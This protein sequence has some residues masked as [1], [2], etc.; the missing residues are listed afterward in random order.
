ML[1]RLLSTLLKLRF[2]GSTSTK[3][4]LYLSIWTN[5]SY[6]P[7][8]SFKSEFPTQAWTLKK[9]GSFQIGTGN[10]FST[11]FVGTLFSCGLTSGHGVLDRCFHYLQLFKTCLTLV[12][13]PSKHDHPAFSFWRRPPE[14]VS[15]SQRRP[16]KLLR[17]L[18][19]R[20]KSFTV[21][22]TNLE[23]Y[24][25]LSMPAILFT[26]TDPL[27]L[28][29]VDRLSLCLKPEELVL[30]YRCPYTYII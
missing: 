14:R 23:R 4:C 5:F 30:A 26:F 16:L 7:F 3:N 8:T 13:K 24:H 9:K 12:F 28:H 10:G 15:T 17:L 20:E 11:F 21:C 2:Q 1:S 18:R 29:M 25:W 22:Y 27:W 19:I 6:P